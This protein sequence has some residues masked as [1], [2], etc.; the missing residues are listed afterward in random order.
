MSLP[1]STRAV[2]RRAICSELGMEFFRRYGSTGYLTCDTDSATDKIV[3]SDLTQADDFWKNQWLYIA[4]DS[5]TGTASALVGDV[6]LIT[7][8]SNVDNSC[9]VDRAYSATPV[10]TLRYEI[11]DV[12]NATEIHNAINRAIRDA[13]PNFFDTVSDETLVLREDTLQYTI[14]ALTYRPWIISEIWIER[15][16]DSKTGTVVSS[17]ATSLTDTATDFSAASSNYIVSIYDGTG[18][19]QLRTCVNG[20]SAG[21]LNIS[22]A[23]T[24]NPDT[25]SKYRFWNTSEQRDDWFRVTSARFDKMEYPN[26]MYLSRLYQGLYGSRIRI[27]YATDALELATDA[28]TTVVPRE[29]VIYKAIAYLAG[30]RTWGRTADREKYAILEQTMNAKAEAFRDKMAFRMDTTLWQE[31]DYS[32]PGSTPSDG[33]PMAW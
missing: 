14:S 6:R 21:V 29:F 20:T 2:L 31:T 25:T 4:E 3:D 24:T 9:I 28:S 18:A 32:T 12:W 11:H 33:N 5:S 17:A 10:G 8:F 15:T 27:T 1:T 7:S 16:F 22:S 26:T 30:S 19:G 13:I 23:W